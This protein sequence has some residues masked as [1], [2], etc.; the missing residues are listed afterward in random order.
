MANLNINL[1]FAID[2]NYQL[3]SSNSSATGPISSTTDL[4][5]IY[6]NRVFAV[7]FTKYGERV[8][9]PNFGSDL[10]KILF[11]TPDV[12]AETAERTIS[13]AFSQWLPDLQLEKIEPLFDG[14]TGYFT[15][16][17]S[18]RLPSGETDGV[19]LN[20]ALFNRFGDV[21]RTFTNG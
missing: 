13:T 8:M 5:T 7:L 9:R 21:L 12:A 4:K 2:N 11:E 6:Q 10:H 16:V 3:V 14:T 19:K 17:I 15:F 20:T 1:P 18:Y